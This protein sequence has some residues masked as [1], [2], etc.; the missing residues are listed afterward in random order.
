VG[1]A[2]QPADRVTRMMSAI[3]EYEMKIDQ[4]RELDSLRRKILKWKKDGHNGL[5]D[6]IM[7]PPAESEAWFRDGDTVE[8]ALL[9][10]SF[11]D[12]SEV[13]T[14]LSDDFDRLRALTAESSHKCLDSRNGVLG[15]KNDHVP[16]M[17]AATVL[18]ALSRSI[19]GASSQGAFSSYARIVYELYK[20]SR[21]DEMLGGAG[22]GSDDGVQT[23]FVTM[24]CVRAL[25]SFASAWRDFANITEALEVF[26]SPD[27]S[28]EWE[29]QHLALRKQAALTTGMEI[30]NRTRFVLGDKD[31]LTIESTGLCKFAQQALASATLVEHYYSNKLNNPD[32]KNNE[33]SPSAREKVCETIAE[34][35]KYLQD[36][37]TAN[38]FG[39]FTK[40][41]S[42]LSDEVRKRL[43]PTQRYLGSVLDHELTSTLPQSSRIA[44][45]AELLFAANGLALLGVVTDARIERGLRAVSQHVTDAGRIPSHR[46]FD[47]FTK[48]YVLHAVTPESIWAFAELA[49]N[50]ADV[51]E[52]AL[53]RKLLRHFEDTWQN[54]AR[55]WRHERDHGKR[56][57]LRWLSAISLRALEALRQAIDKRINEL[58]LSNLSVR[59]PEDL[60]NITLL[61]LFYPDFGLVACGIR[62]GIAITLQHM[63]AHILGVRPKGYSY[64]LILHGPPGTGKTTIPEALAKSCCVPLVEVTPSDI[65]LAGTEMFETRARLVFQG[66]SMLTKVV[67]L[68]DE[69]DSILWSREAK[70]KP[71][72]M[73]RFLTPGMLPKLK[74]LHER[75]D[76]QCSAFILSTNLI[77]GLDKAATREGRFDKKIG[78]YPPDLLSRRGR[79]KAEWTK[80]RRKLGNAEKFPDERAFRNV[81]EKSQGAPMSRLARPDWF[82]AP[83]SDKP[84][85][86]SPLSYL[87][88][89]LD[90]VRWPSPE[91]QLPKSLEQDYPGEAKETLNPEVFSELQEWSFVVAVDN[92]FSTSGGKD[93][94]TFPMLPEGSKDK[95]EQCFAGGDW[96]SW[97][98][99]VKENINMNYV[100]DSH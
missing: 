13:N 33:L 1:F 7:K 95:F 56:L 66:L 30:A 45:S 27:Q 46:P 91:K 86:G 10:Y 57:C 85:E 22:A 87:L 17:R 73:L 79:L 52:P 4:A 61:D 11:S 15:G 93:I 83:R 72:G 96:K 58:V 59:Q 81:V 25:L 51:I 71:E 37:T 60:K 29:K 24:W 82:T 65:L 34:F 54:D 9:L 98:S 19:E 44:D 77:G 74:E 43:R 100:A 31:L 64:S 68:F 97:Q 3:T 41:S 92:K 23:A 99:Y 18:D 88:N 76:K 5:K 8:I 47:T 2:N 55:G 38:S 16:V 50:A 63:R 78:I 94:K 62:D 48:G 35:K 26:H 89:P 69:F 20:A 21:P 14:K 12:S 75:A 70:Q 6:A 80:W 49:T 28:D 40:P 67:I 53:V 90:E 84:S 36:M 42:A 39:K 32:N